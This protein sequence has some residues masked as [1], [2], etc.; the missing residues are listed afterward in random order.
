MRSRQIA[1]Q[2]MRASFSARGDVDAVG[3]ADPEPRPGDLSD[4]LS[5][6]RISKSLSMMFPTASSRPP[7]GYR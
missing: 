3:V 7:P 6:S 5:P 2:M 4:D 1:M